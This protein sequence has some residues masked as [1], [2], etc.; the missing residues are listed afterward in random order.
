MLTS[1]VELAK[2]EKVRQND[3]AQL[4]DSMFKDAGLEDKEVLTYID[5]K[6]MMKDFNGDFLA[7]GLDLK[8][9]KHNFL[10]ES[11]N[12][13]RMQNCAT[14]YVDEGKSWLRIKWEHLTTFLEE[15]RQNIFYLLVFFTINIWLFA[16]RFIHYSF[17]S[18]HS[19]LRHIMGVGISITRGCAAALSF[20]YSVLLL[21]MS[22]NLLTKLKDTS[23]HQYIPTDAHSQFHKVRSKF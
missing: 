19:D 6:A 10:D 18:E 15:N 20:D 4:I 23:L 11:D 1:L 21:S 16:E 17:M 12:I 2:T 13:A 7:V 8:G 5:F 22:R 3:V 9:A 14:E